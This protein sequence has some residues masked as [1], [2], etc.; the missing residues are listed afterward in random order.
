[1][2]DYVEILPTDYLRL[3]YVTISKLYI[4]KSKV[5]TTFHLSGARLGQLYIYQIQSW[6]NFS[7]IRCKVGATLHLSDPRLGQ[8]YIYQVQGWDN[9][10]FIR[11]KDGTVAVRLKL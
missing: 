6:D 7:F 9:F 10:T 2:K 4:I 8:L 3:E 1:M 11:S 5:G